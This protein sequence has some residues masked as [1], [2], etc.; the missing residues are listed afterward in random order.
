MTEALGLSSLTPVG[1]TV[2]GKVASTKYTSST[3]SGN[4]RFLVD[5]QGEGRTYRLP[6]VPDSSI[7]GRIENSE[8]REINHRFFLD[9]RGR[10]M[11]AEVA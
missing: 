4:P 10:I 5:I 3:R 1:L 8:F 2:V 9:S 7:A 11:R 6:T